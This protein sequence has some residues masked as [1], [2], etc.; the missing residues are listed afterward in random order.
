MTRCGGKHI[1]ERGWKGPGTYTNPDI[2]SL[3][4]PVIRNTLCEFP[5]KTVHVLSGDGAVVVHVASQ[6]GLVRRV[7]DE[8]DAL[9]GAKVCTRKFRHGVDC[10]LRTLRVALED[11]ALVW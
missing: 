4:H 7:A 6:T 1:R 3:E 5:R 8:E 9:D 11:E 10:C 2:K